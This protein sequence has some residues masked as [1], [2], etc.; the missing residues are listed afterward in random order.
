M[1]KITRKTRNFEKFINKI[2]KLNNTSV[3]SGYFIEQGEH[4]DAGIPYTDLINMHHRGLGNFPRR[5]VLNP[6]L[7]SMTSFEFTNSI[8]KGLKNYLYKDKQLAPILD[9]FGEDISSIAV[10]F[11]GVPSSYN[12]SNSSTWAELKGGDT[13][14]VFE[15]NLRD[16]WAYRTSENNVIKANKGRL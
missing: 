10:S 13:P 9:D 11:F 1:G 4:P 2:K 7:L 6:T 15:G 16:A 12:P 14:L 8:H 5:D 3:E